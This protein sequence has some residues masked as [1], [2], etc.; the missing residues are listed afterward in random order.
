MDSATLLLSATC[1]T[2]ITTLEDC[3]RLAKAEFMY[4]LPHAHPT[5]TAL[6]GNA[7]HHDDAL[8]L[9]SISPTHSSSGRKRSVKKNGMK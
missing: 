5:D 1:D 9:P 8:S 4:Q 3:L 6:N 7:S 2:F